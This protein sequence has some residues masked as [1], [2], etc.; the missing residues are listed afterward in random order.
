MTILCVDMAEKILQQTQESQDRFEHIL[1]YAFE[2]INDAVLFFNLEGAALLVNEAAKKIL[3]IKSQISGSFWDFFTDDSLGFSMREALKFGISHKRLYRRYFE[4]DLEITTTFL[5]EGQKTSHGLLIFIR[6]ITEKQRLISLIHRNEHMQ[7]MGEMTTT[8]THEI[9]NP[10]GGIRGYASLLYRD[11][12][13]QHSLQEIAGLILD[14][15]KA[16][17]RQIGSI[18]QYARVPQLLLQSSEINQ[19]LRQTIQSIKI[20]PACPYN[21]EW[22]IHIPLGYFFAPID[23]DAMKSVFLNLIFNAFQAMP[24]GGRLTI[25]LLKEESCYKIAISD[26]GIGMDEKLVAKLFTPFFTTKEMGNGLGLVEVKKIIH[27]HFGTIDVRS[28]VGK[29]TTFTLTLPVKR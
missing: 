21:I 8:I 7:K 17:E 20:D 9:R 6:D 10:L 22:D 28:T 23:P 16:L 24:L 18:L 12:E 15:T 26:T 1:R 5:Y 27:A 14:G 3:N 29:G 11:L 4:K 2:Q 25:S 13:K 19:F